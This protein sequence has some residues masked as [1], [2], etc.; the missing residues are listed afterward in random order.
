MK[1]TETPIFD[2]AQATMSEFLDLYSQITS[3]MHRLKDSP[4]AEREQWLHCFLIEQSMMDSDAAQYLVTKLNLAPMDSKSKL[5]FGSWQYEVVGCKISGKKR[6]ATDVLLKG[7]ESR[8]GSQYDVI[9]ADDGVVISAGRCYDMKSR[10]SHRG[11][12]IT[13]AYKESGVQVLYNHLGGVKVSPG[14]YIH[15]GQV[16]GSAGS[17]DGCVE[18]DVRRNGRRLDAAE[19]LGVE[20][21]R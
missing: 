7:I 6:V 16:I 11:L 18:I 12:H 19:W 17:K 14:E 21:K 15:K 9:A 13:M 5:V 8:V 4:P 10:A 1:K 3:S 20:V 2:A